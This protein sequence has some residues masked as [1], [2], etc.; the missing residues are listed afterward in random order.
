MIDHAQSSRNRVR[1]APA[2]PIEKAPFGL[3]PPQL[4]GDT[5]WDLVAAMDAVIPPMD[6][7]DVPVNLRLELPAGFY[8]DIRN[9]SSMA[10]R[11]LYVDQALID[12]GYRGPL[13]VF[14]RNMNL[15]AMRAIPDEQVAMAAHGGLVVPGQENRP[16]QGPNVAKAPAH[17]DE[18]TITVKA[19][20][21][22]AQL[23]FVR[24]CPV[25]PEMVEMI[26]D[27]T[28]RGDRGFGSTGL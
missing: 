27:G 17:L 9:R 22:I 1:M 5:G 25:W 28:A 20:E 10:R 3:C 16:Y 24:G 13:F 23:V 26:D 2:Y 8:A 21:R 4:E 15:P 14:L 19:G 7:A 18:G 12:N 11:N 6:C